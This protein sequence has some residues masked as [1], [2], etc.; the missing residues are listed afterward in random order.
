MKNIK[1]TW[2]GI[3]SII[4]LKAEDS[5]SPKIIKTK[6]G[7]TVGDPVISADYFNFFFCSVAQLVQEKL[8]VP[9]S[10]FKTIFQSHAMIHL[11]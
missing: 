5:E 10:C 6:H 4:S 7:E 3:K 11:L 2:K 1:N 9:L 8:T